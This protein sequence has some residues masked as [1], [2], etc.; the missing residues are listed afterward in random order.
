LGIRADLQ[1]IGNFT[2]VFYNSIRLRS[3]YPNVP[4]NLDDVLVGT[5]ANYYIEN[6]RVLF[7]DM[8][9]YLN[10]KINDTDYGM[11]SSYA[12]STNISDVNDTLSRW[13]EEYGQYY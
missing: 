6:S 7:K 13:V 1:Y 12:P 2:S 4:I 5:T 8:G 3:E 9:P 10:I 11:T